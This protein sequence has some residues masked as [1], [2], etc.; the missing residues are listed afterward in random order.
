MVWNHII[1]QKSLKPGPWFNIKISSYQY[2]KFHCGDKTVERSSYL[3]NGISYTGKM[4]SFV[5]NRPPGI[6]SWYK[7]KL[8]IY[9][10]FIVELGSMIYLLLSIIWWRVTLNHV[11]TRRCL[12][13]T[14]GAFYQEGSA[15]IPAWISNQM[16]GKVWDQNYLSTPKLQRCNLWSLT[17]DK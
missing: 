2:R 4:I 11:M 5:L 14:W 16:P 13:A 10:F 6:C 7:T 1:K 3:Q 8:S 12:V 17:M 9:A 15:L